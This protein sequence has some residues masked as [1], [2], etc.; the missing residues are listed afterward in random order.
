MAD[1]SEYEKVRLENI[2]RNEAFLSS[3]GISGVQ[4][5]KSASPLKAKKRTE[6][7]RMPAERSAAVPARSS[8]RPRRVT[9]QKALDDEH[10]LD[11]Q[12]YVN[13]HV[14]KIL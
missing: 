3:I 14:C 11:W 1:L 7:K 9:A 10:W 6:Q 12:A 5:R 2:K 8:P 4:P 13:M